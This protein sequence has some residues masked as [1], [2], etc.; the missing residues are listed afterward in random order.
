MTSGPGPVRVMVIFGTRPEAIKLAP[1]IR[2]LTAS[3]DFAVVTVSTAQHRAMLDQVTR[4]FEITPDVDLD[5][6]RDRQTLVDT[7]CRALSGLELVVAERQPDLILV[8]GDTL[9]TFSAALAGHCR[10][11]PVAHLEA[12]L[13][14]DERY[15]P[16]PEEMNRRLTTQL[17]SLHLAPTATSK[18]NL[19]REGVDPA[20]VCVTG[21]T[22][23]DALLWTV[24]SPGD[25]F[26]DGALATLAASD[27]RVL[28]V[29]AHRRE[30]W[31]EP[32]AAVGRAVAGIARREPALQVVLPLHA[33]PVVRECILPSVEGLENVL[34]TGPL[35]YPDFVRLLSR[36][37][38]VLTDS[39]GIQEEAP[40]LG[41]PVLVMRRDT[42]RPEGV[43]AG[44]ARLVGTDE[45]KIVAAV[46]GL[47]HDEAAYERMSRAV[48][49]YGDGRAAQRVVAALKHFV[50]RGPAPEQFAPS[51][52]VTTS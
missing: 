51:A 6:M 4:L 35:A 44:T 36:A 13:R 47:L 32:L 38:L 45:R 3:R 23:I 28:L 27:R 40:S 34:V 26:G 43:E 21:N 5:L 30:S 15:S 29:T 37:H 10:Q 46:L 50:G 16:F 17:A 1:V 19:L 14:T 39:G 25:G 48:S 33:N 2:D 20:T 24:R 31:G 52:M 41:K 11:V 8:Q 49:P 12:G 42:E 7:T 22:V 18:E 9:T